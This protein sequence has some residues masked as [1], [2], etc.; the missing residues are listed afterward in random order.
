MSQTWRLVF[1]LLLKLRYNCMFIGPIFKFSRGRNTRTPVL[2]GPECFQML[3][4]HHFLQLNIVT[5]W[6]KIEK[7]KSQE[8]C[9]PQ[10]CKSECGYNCTKRRIF[11]FC[12]SCISVWIRGTSQIFVDRSTWNAYRLLWVAHNK[13]GCNKNIY[14]FP[15]PIMEEVPWLVR[16]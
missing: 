1:P 11:C 12:G 13:V 6:T 16:N 14:R 5:Y 15:E 3:A 2:K 4:T 8:P 7:S 10:I 9:D